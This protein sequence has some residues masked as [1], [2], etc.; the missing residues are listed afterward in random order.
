MTE[1]HLGCYRGDCL[2]REWRFVSLG[3]YAA[4]GDC[5]VL[6]ECATDW[7]VHGTRIEQVAGTAAS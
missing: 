7:R 5:P 1:R 2:V 4:G 3:C 6:L